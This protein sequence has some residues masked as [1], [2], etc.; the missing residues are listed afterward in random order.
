[1]HTAIIVG[2]EKVVVTVL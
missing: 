1:M 2:K